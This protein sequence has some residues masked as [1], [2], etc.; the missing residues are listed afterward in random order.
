MI[1]HNNQCDTMT[2]VINT[3]QDMSNVTEQTDDW[4][5]QKNFRKPTTRNKWKNAIKKLKNM[6]AEGK[7]KKISTSH[8]VS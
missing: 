6:L 2:R 5:T 7:T 3:T 4:M 8:F 1:D